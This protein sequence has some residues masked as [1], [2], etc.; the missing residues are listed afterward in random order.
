MNSS[1]WKHIIHAPKQSMISR[2]EPMSRAKAARK[3]NVEDLDMVRDG[4]GGWISGG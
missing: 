4:L 1:W 2:G 3:K